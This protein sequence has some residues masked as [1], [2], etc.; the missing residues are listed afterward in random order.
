MTYRLIDSMLE[1]RENEAALRVISDNLL[2]FPGDAEL[3]ERQAKTY[4]RL[5]R[6]VQEHR[7]QAEAYYLLHC[8]RWLLSN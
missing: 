4:A 3:Y 8:C 2:S 1:L 7:A 5:G 6:R